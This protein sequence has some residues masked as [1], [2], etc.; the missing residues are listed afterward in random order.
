L[1]KTQRKIHTVFFTTPGCPPNSS[2]TDVQR[3][4]PGCLSANQVAIEKIAQMKPDV[5]I[6]AG[7]WARYDGITNASIVDQR[8]IRVIIER[9]NSMG[10][11][12]VVGVGQFPLWTVA[13]PRIL[14]HDCHR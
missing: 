8:S 10:I 7:N 1:E 12:R 3:V 11:S 9:L 5:V 6:L 14:A 13:V 2:Y 4:L